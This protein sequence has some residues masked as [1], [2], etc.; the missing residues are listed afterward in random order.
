MPASK[1]KDS[2]A[3]LNSETEGTASPIENQEPPVSNTVS[4]GPVAIAEE[5]DDTPI[6]VNSDRPPLN[7]FFS[8]DSDA[9]SDEQLKE[10]V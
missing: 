9:V 1:P 10:I 8:L 2:E 7:Q 6:D 5:K 3:D 4:R